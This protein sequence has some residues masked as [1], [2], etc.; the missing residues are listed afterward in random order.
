MPLRVSALI[1]IPRDANAE[2]KGQRP[3]DDEA[4]GQR[5]GGQKD[6]VRSPNQEVFGHGTRI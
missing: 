2:A 6:Q 3:A 5:L 1:G 4:E